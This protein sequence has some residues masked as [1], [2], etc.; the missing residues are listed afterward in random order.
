M[1]CRTAR[2]GRPAARCAAPVPRWL[3]GLPG[4]VA[5]APPAAAPAAAPPP[6]PPSPAADPAAPARAAAAAAEAPRSAAADLLGPT[7]P[8]PQDY[9]AYHEEPPFRPRRNRARIWTI[10]G[11]RRRLADARRASAAI[12]GSGC[13]ASAAA[14]R[15]PAPT[16][17]TPLDIEARRTR[18]LES[19]N[20]LLAVAWRDHQPDRRGP[21]RAADP[22]RDCR[23]RQG[24]VV[25]SWSISPP[26]R[27][28]QPHRR[29]TFDSA[30]MDVPQGAE[31]VHLEPRQI[32]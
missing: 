18:R 12:P 1:W 25:Y 9:D 27:E 10:A 26:V 16:A 32:L 24:R 28:L 5:R 2:S 3:L 11:D 13:R 21:A 14:S 4:S 30:E 8:A 15:Y 29:V 20:E 23:T 22:R 17:A 7:P 19:G 6:P 31:R